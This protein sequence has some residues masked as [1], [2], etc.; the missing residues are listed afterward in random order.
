[1][2]NDRRKSLKPGDQEAVLLGCVQAGSGARPAQ[3]RRHQA[4]VIVEPG[5]L[6][7]QL[8]YELSGRLLLSPP[9][10][11]HQPI[12]LVAKTCDTQGEHR[13]HQQPDEG[14]E[15]SRA[16]RTNVPAPGR[17][18]VSSFEWLF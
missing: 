1:M 9:E 6:L 11:A 2:T 17:P 16:H 18:R 12:S 4:P 15:V 5:Q 7:F 14:D 13:R 10:V 8:G 3:Q